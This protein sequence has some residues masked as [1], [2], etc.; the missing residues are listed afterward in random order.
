LIPI[1]EEDKTLSPILSAPNAVSLLMKSLESSDLEERGLALTVATNLSAGEVNG[2]ALFED[3]RMFKHA[4]EI[5][6]ST[7]GS[8]SAGDQQLRDISMLS[9][10]NFSVNP[11][12]T[13]RMV[14][15]GSLVP[16]I[17][18]FMIAPSG[19]ERHHAVKALSY[20]SQ[21]GMFQTRVFNLD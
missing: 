21:D 4:L 20:I 7:E 16:I 5:L 13:T 8:K 2:S 10:S 18:S 9:L 15:L 11:S 12:N 14:E 1:E 19:M 6:N 17:K 3:G